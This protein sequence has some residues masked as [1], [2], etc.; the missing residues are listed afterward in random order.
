ML[1]RGQE[2]GERVEEGS[3][4]LKPGLGMCDVFNGI[5]CLLSW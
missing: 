5:I 3:T 1:E 2:A 4:R